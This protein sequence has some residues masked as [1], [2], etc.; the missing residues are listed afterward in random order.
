LNRIRSGLE[1]AIKNA[2]LRMLSV[3]LL[4]GN[5]AA[6]V[7]L[8]RFDFAAL[9]L[10]HF[11]I[12]FGCGFLSS[13]FVLAL[14]QTCGFFRGQLSGGHTLIDAFLLIGLALVNAGRGCWVF[15]RR[16]G[17]DRGL[18]KRGATSQQGDG[19]DEGANVHVNF[20]CAVLTEASFETDLSA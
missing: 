11:A 13:N 4:L 16:C 3:V 2:S 12:G 18:C 15:G 20:L 8:V 5:G 9:T 17:W 14:L 19:G 6:G 10:G 1:E 7:V